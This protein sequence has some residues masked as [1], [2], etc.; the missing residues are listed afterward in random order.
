MLIAY[1]LMHS[2]FVSLYLNMRRLSLSLRPHS[3]SLGFWL[4]T[5]SLASSCLAFM[6]SL[7]TAW[8]LEI[9]VNP[10]LLGEAL[11][12][13]VITVGFEKPFLLTRAVFSNPAIGPGGAYAGT[14]S[15]GSM[16]PVNGN[17]NAN[18]HVNPSTMFGLRF[19]PPIPSRD[20]VLG[21]V[22]KTGVSIVR[23]Y[24]IEVAV[25]VLGAMS[26]V[27]G[28]REFCQLAAVILVFDGLFLMGFFV[29]VLTIMV[30][31]SLSILLN[32]HLRSCAEQVL[33]FRFTASKSFAISDV[34]TRLQ[35]SPDY[36]TTRTKAAIPMLK[37]LRTVTTTLL[38]LLKSS[39]SVRNLSDSLLVEDGERQERVETLWRNSRFFL[40]LRSWSFTHSTSSRLS[41]RR[42]LSDDT[43][44]TL[45]R[46]P[47]F[48]KS[49]LRIPS[50]ARL[51]Y[52]SSP[53]TNL[54]LNYSF[55]SFPLSTST[56]SIAPLLLRP[57]TQA[58]PF[59]TSHRQPD[60]SLTSINS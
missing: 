42:P 16:T 50:S 7:L 44:T 1:V 34:P 24:A 39:P 38:Q 43:W 56:P 5:L 58:L 13:L 25:L 6:F 21:A 2:T 30:E 37:V 9:N 32:D 20:I 35:I 31:V 12:F 60:R 36:S 54:E 27:A 22:G 59:L 33:L 51:S 47:T 10:V 4:A 17:G 48:L 26:G 14:T 45:L 8:Y 41:R 15:R 55:M 29:S 46:L 57:S 18:G 23:D 28:L 52:N 3:A 19:A 40:S 11:P 49:T 53:L